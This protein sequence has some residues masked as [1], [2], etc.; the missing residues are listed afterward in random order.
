[1][2]KGKRKY[3]DISGFLGIF[4]LVLIV[5]Y[6]GKS[7][8]FRIDMTSD[9]R[10]SMADA[11]RNIVRDLD[12]DVTVEIYLKGDFPS[13]FERLR[14]AVEETMEQLRVYAGGNLHYHFMNPN[15]IEN[16]EERY[17]FYQQ[18]VQKGIR[19]TNLHSREQGGQ[20]QKMVFP[21]AVIKYKDQETGVRFLKGNSNAKPEEQINQSIEGLEYEFAS[22]IRKITTNSKKVIGFTEGHGELSR[23]ETDGIARLLKEYYRVERVPYT[24]DTDLSRYDALVVARPTKPFTDNEK[25]NLDQYIINGGNVFFF[26]DKI[27]MNLD[28]LRDGSSAVTVPFQLKLDEL[29][30]NY[31]VRINNDLIKDMQCGAIPLVSGRSQRG[32]PETKKMPWQYYPLIT[33]FSEHPVVRNLPMV[34]SKFVS[35]IDTVQSAGIKQTP[36]LYTSQYSQIVPSPSEISFREVAENPDPK[37]YRHGPIPIGYLLE[38]KFTSLYEHRLSAERRKA[39]G[40]KKQNKPAKV[41]VFSDG[42]IIKNNVNPQNGQTYPLGFE[43]YMQKHFANDDLAV[44]LFDY[45]LGEEALVNVRAK[46]IEMRPLDQYKAEQERMKWQLINLVLPLVVVILFGIIRFYVRKRK[47]EGQKPPR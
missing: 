24:A 10:Y 46:E 15:S 47:F 37:Q 19:P 4:I 20:T 6:I 32:T 22:A 3:K 40:F 36:L 28:S 18:L 38:G 41:V 12:D 16:K 26:L 34:I 21:G 30:F 25:I 29:L 43:R 45:V 7:Y 8:Y 35:S 14:N 11:T 2:F 13:A 9:N 31:G 5:N 33:N 39:I 17:K 42:D 23:R 1:M 44:N 27:R